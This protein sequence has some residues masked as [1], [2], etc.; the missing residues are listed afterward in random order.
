MSTMCKL[1]D[2]SAALPPDNHDLKACLPLVLWL[3]RHFC[4]DQW[5]YVWEQKDSRLFFINAY[6]E[7]CICIEN[8]ALSHTQFTLKVDEDDEVI[9]LQVITPLE[10]KMFDKVPPAPW[11]PSVAVTGRIICPNLRGIVPNQLAIWCYWRQKEQRQSK[12]FGLHYKKY[13]FVLV[14]GV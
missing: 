4:F 13:V 9:I 10:I 8:I 6:S 12:L 5:C 1:Y 2:V 7:R 11:G 14:E 3:Y